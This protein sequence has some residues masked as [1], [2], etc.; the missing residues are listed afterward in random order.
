MKRI[1]AWD[2]EDQWSKQPGFRRITTRKE[3]F[4]AVQKGGAAKLA[5]VASGT[6]IKQEFDFWAGCALFWGRYFGAC[7][8]IGE[9]V[10]DVTTPSKAPG[11]WGMLLRRG[12]K[13]GITIYALSQRWAE[14]DKT[15]IGNAT[16]FVCCAFSNDDDVVY[17]ARK[18]RIPVDQLAALR[19]VETA[20]TITCPFIRYEVSTSKIE[21]GKLSFT[22]KR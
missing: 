13:R 20:T 22:K 4:E 19:K 18:T 5:Y 17:M 7:V 14:A 6:N 9:E 21:H 8:A 15:A 10:A 16:E 2:P 1:I 12:L 3:L 11:N